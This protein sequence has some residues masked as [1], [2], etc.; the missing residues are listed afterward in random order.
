VKIVRSD[1]AR[2]TEAE[3]AVVVIDVLRSFTTA[4]YAFA[5]GAG[6]I[7]LVNALP[8]VDV[9]KARFP[10]AVTVGAYGGGAPIPGFDLPNSP[11]AVRQHDVAGRT[12]ILHTAGGVR[13]LVAARRASV[14]MA[15]SLVCARATARYLAA[16]APPVVTLLV[17]GIWTD[18]NGDEDHACGDLIAAL[19]RGEEPPAAPYESRV[20]ESDFGRRFVAGD[21]PALPLA[22]LEASAQVD[23]F[24]FAMPVTRRPW[25]LTIEPFAVSGAGES[26]TRKSATP[27]P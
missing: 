4:A 26:P 12:I 22:D 19:L 8:A 1:L 21:N 2:S 10:D 3:G 9:V 7:V 18:R 11:P 24:D 20:R 23:R 16:L 15:G 5:A 14:L 6:R 27:A 13:G 17:T 25:G